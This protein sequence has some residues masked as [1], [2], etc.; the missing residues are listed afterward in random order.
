MNHACEPTLLPE[1]VVQL[2]GH[3]RIV[4]LARR[5]I[6]PGEELTFDYST[7]SSHKRAFSRLP[8]TSGC[9]SS[10][11]MRTVHTLSHR[12]AAHDR[13]M[14]ADPAPD[15]LDLNGGLVKQDLRPTPELAVVRSAAL[16]G[17]LHR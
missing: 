3:F 8:H 1:E 17:Q 9:A 7:R 5:H 14:R 6:Y 15:L 10:G 13:G 12:V 16:A 4:F 11:I 2:R